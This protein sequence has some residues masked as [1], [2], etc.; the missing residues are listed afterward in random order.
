MSADENAEL[1]L[2]FFPKVARRAIRVIVKMKANSALGPDNLPVTFFQ[3]FWEHLQEV[4]MLMFQEF[5]IGT[6]NMSRLNLV[7][8]R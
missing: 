3:K 5:Y 2:P 8:L 6:L 1:T 7:W 4:I